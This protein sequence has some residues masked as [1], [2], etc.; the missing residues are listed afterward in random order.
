MV[1]V[2]LQIYIYLRLFSLKM[3]E[4]FKDATDHLQLLVLA[5][6]PGIGMGT[7]DAHLVS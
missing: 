3:I 2:N 1:N 5:G 6:T 4:K 7:M